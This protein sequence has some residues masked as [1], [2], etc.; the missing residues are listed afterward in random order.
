MGDD[1]GRAWLSREQPHL[2]DGHAR[3]DAGQFIA[4]VAHDTQLSLQQDQH[5][6]AGIAEAVD[7]FAHLEVA[8]LT[9]SQQALH[10]ACIEAAEDFDL[11]DHLDE[12]V[13]LLVHTAG[14]VRSRDGGIAGVTA[15]R[16]R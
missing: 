16:R 6:V 13:L 10:V 11:L 4:R 3:P 7:L 5:F 14:P 8:E 12:H 2:A 1:I 15:T 9:D